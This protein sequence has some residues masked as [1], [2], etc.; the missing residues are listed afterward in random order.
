MRKWGLSEEADANF[1]NIDRD[2][3]GKLRF[4]E[5]ADWALRNRLDLE[6]DYDVEV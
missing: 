3:S 5:F 2:G 4:D 1:H 6:G